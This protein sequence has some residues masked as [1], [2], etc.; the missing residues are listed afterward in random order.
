MNIFENDYEITDDTVVTLGKF[1]GLHEGHQKLIKETVNEARIR[2]YKSLVYTFNQNP[3]NVLKN[4]EIRNLISKKEKIDIL[5]SMCV[6]NIVFQ[7]FTYDFSRLLP[8]EFF[9]SI[10]RDR[11]KAQMVI[12]G[13]NYRFGRDAIGDVDILKSLCE[14]NKIELKI[15]EP[16]VK[17]GEIVSSSL[18]REKIM[19]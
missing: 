8:E 18:I 6:D 12:V 17:D 15:I 9:E 7:D 2:G 11:L 5:K 10:I 14:K 19:T 13:F 4:A 3:R 1:D 16:I